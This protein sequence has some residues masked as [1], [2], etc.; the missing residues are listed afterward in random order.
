[1]KIEIIGKFNFDNIYEVTI[2]DMKKEL[3]FSNKNAVFEVADTGT[4]RIYIEKQ[5]VKVH[6]AAILIINFLTLIL[7]GIINIILF[8]DI[9]NWADNIEAYSMRCY[10]DIQVKNDTVIKIS[11]IESKYIEMNKCFTLPKINIYP[12]VDCITK[13]LPNRSSIVHNFYLFVKKIASA[14]IIFY[15]LFSYLLYVAFTIHSLWMAVFL[16]TVIVGGSLI[17]YFSILKAAKKK[18]KL[19]EL[20]DFQSN[21]IEL[22]NTQQ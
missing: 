18:N 9:N 17:I 4:Y 13:I 5:S 21:N 11:I 7:Q 1:M 2:G 12:N 22:E 14:G 3:S 16:I 20:F 15:V 6:K 19:L 10:F 8:N